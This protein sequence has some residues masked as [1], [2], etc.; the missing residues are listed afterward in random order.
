LLQQNAIVPHVRLLRDSA[1]TRQE[2]LVM[3]S[4][5]METMNPPDAGARPSARKTECRFA[6]IHLRARGL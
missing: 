5:S 4:D 6:W 1:T 3:A 2:F